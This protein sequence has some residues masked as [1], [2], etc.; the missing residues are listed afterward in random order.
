LSGCAKLVTD[1][2]E[3]SGWIDNQSALKH[4]LSLL[5]YV[6][7]DYENPDTFATLKKE[8]GRARN[9]AYYL[10]IPPSLFET[11]IKGWRLGQT[12]HFSKAFR[13]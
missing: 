4:F 7:G 9:P 6:S 2:V 12:P 8:L 3:R 11:V 5:G 10:A 13:R 1:S